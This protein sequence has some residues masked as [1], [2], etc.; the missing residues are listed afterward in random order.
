VRAL[1]QSFLDPEPHH[2]YFL[3]L[4]SMLAR[5]APDVEFDVVGLRPPDAHL[6]ALTEVRCGVAALR[7]AVYAERE[8]YDVVVIGHFQEPLLREIR[9]SV[10][11]PVIGLGESALHA[12]TGKLGLITIADVFVPWHEEQLRRYRLDDRLVGVL[13][14]GIEPAGFMP[15]MEPGRARSL[16]LDAVELACTSLAAAGADTIVPAGAL[17]PV[18]LFGVEDDVGMPGLPV[19]NCVAVAARA[20]SRA[21]PLAAAAGPPPGALAEFLDATGGP[22]AEPAR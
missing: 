7:N 16:L 19:Q 11:L 4:R 5:L 21:E 20:A 2:R 6:H 12:A 3:Q 9:L 13:P 15:A 18:V 8:G 17:I 10:T 22:L 1:W 14:L